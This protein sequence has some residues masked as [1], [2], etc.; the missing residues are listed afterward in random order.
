[1][2][3]LHIAISTHSIADTVEDYSTRLG[4]P[5]C[6]Y[7]AGQYD[8]SSKSGELRHYTQTQHA[9]LIA[10]IIVAALVLQSL[11]VVPAPAPL[12]RDSSVAGA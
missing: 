7:V 9:R 4:V 11:S 5:P 6:S 8:V 12:R 10:I 3:K 1:M 2:K